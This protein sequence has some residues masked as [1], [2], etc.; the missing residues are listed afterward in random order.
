MN[1]INSVAHTNSHKPEIN[2][3]VQKKNRTKNKWNK[4]SNIQ[5]KSSDEHFFLK[6]AQSQ[7]INF[8]HSFHTLKVKKAHK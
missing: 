1:E 7:N 8:T 6:N 4:T 3:C 5:I 2:S